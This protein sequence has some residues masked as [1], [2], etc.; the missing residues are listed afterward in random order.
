MVDD[1]RWWVTTVGVLMVVWEVSLPS[2]A[3][4]RS[5]SPPPLLEL[6]PLT[7]EGLRS[8][9]PGK[10]ALEEASSTAGLQISANDMR[11]E[12]SIEGGYLLWVRA[13][14]GMASIMLTE[15]TEAPGSN[16]ATYAY[17]TTRED[18]SYIDERRI[19]DGEFLSSEGHFLI[20]STPERHPEFGFAFRIFIPYIVNY[21]YPTSRHG[22]VQVLDGTY[23]S[24]RAFSLPFADYRGA[25][26][27]N[28]FVVRVQQAPRS[29]PAAENYMPDTL[30]SYRDIAAE[31]DGVPLLSR[32]PDDT[33][34]LIRELLPDEGETLDL[35]VALDTTQSM[36]DDMPILQRELTSALQEEL[37]AYRQV[38]VGF[39][40]YRD[41]YEEYLVRGSGFLDSYQAVQ[42]TLDRVRIA[43]GRDLPEAI[44]EALWAGIKGFEWRSPNRMIILIGDAPP[45]PRPRGSVTRE[46]VY[47]AAADEGI[48]IH[49][50]ILPQ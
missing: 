4:Q 25:Y 32:G 15:S 48:T 7:G 6:P 13:K 22:E 33:V 49:T 21:G 11:I 26:R 20:D 8:V 5:P 18:P 9:P 45:H 28:P 19:L 50:I 46:Q 40:F 10:N 37:A 23:L 43:G 34:P 17:R 2:L 47:A 35:V 31:T 12:Q 27:D 14:E 3:A 44:Y 41:Y 29:G 38:R 39:M 24:V 36:H 1:R 16:A 42:A 30:V